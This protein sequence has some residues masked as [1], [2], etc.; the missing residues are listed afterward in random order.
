[1][2]H[3]S[4]ILWTETAER[5]VRAA[6][7]ETPHTPTLSY[8]G[9]VNHLSSTQSHLPTSHHDGKRAQSQRKVEGAFPPAQ[10]GER[11][12]IQQT[13]HRP[14]TVRPHLPTIASDLHANSYNDSQVPMPPMPGARL[15]PS[16]ANGGAPHGPPELQARDREKVR[17]DGAVRESWS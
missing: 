7:S 10:A 14:A 15:G 17:Y 6:H 9:H 16:T 2:Y 11:R 4:D 12:Q 5:P 13:R 8:R 3:V 1:M